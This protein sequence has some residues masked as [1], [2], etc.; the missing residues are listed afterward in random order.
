MKIWFAAF[1]VACGLARGAEHPA[2]ATKIEKPGLPNLHRISANLYR[3]AQPTA[4][5]MRTLQK[6]GIKTV[7]NLR[8]FR[9]DR[10]EAAG[11]RLALEEIS[12]EPWHPEIKDV[13]RFLR[14]VTD[15]QREP[16]FVHCQYGADRTGMMIAIY[17]VV[18][19]GW[20]KREAIDEMTKGDFGFHPMWKN[21]IAYFE[22]L[23]IGALK[24]RAARSSR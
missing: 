13:V 22:K 2:W 14:L 1:F 11:T 8:V 18:V 15:H 4:E 24:E 7:I 12:F 3:G 10:K 21:L 23:D 19:D 9:S 6:M 17:R 16:I 20:T 5:G